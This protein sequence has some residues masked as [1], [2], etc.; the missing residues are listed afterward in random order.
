MRASD[1]AVLALQGKVVTQNSRYSVIHGESGVWSLK[2]Q[3]VRETDRGC[4]YCQINTQPLKKQSGCIDVHLPPDISDKDSSTDLTIHE[5]QDARLFCSAT[6]HPTPKILFRKDDGT[7]IIFRNNNSDLYSTEIYSGK[8]LNFLK[9]Q[10]DQMGA[11][12]C[13]A[14]NGIEP[15]VSKRMIL[16]VQFPP[17][18]TTETPILG[19]VQESDRQID[20]IVESFPVSINYWIK[21]SNFKLNQ[22][23]QNNLTMLQQ[24]NKYIISDKRLSSYKTRMLL[25]INNFNSMDA[26]RYICLSSNPLGRANS[27]I[28][29]YEIKLTT[30]STTT[31]R[32]TTTSTTTTTMRPSTRRT[33]YP[34]TTTSTLPTTTSTEMDLEYITYNSL[35][36]HVGVE[37]YQHQLNNVHS[38]STRLWQSFLLCWCVLV[39]LKFFNALPGG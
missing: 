2:I 21:E 15:A 10:R 5:F 4:Y 22:W 8:L 34:L 13:I 20:C 28:K 30:T 29:I 23:D 11:Y 31:V 9:V 14:A 3:N 38:N 37:S 19:A 25:T 17:N 12:L 33:T 18:V 6:G 39:K 35:D 27:T 7:P 16:N 26:G 1:H 24:S 36:L 32:T